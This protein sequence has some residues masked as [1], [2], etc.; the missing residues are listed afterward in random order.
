MFEQ[1]FAFNAKIIST[2]VT[3]GSTCG[4]YNIRYVTLLRLYNDNYILRCNGI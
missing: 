2:I 3:R 1:P 4:L